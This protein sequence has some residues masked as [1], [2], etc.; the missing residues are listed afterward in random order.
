[1]ELG[2]LVPVLLLAVGDWIAVWRGSKTAEYFFKPAT[3]A[4]LIAIAVVLDAST[5]VLVALWLSLLGDVFLMLPRDLLVQGLLSFLF[6][7]VF[8][9]WAF[10]PLPSGWM[11]IAV[12]VGVVALPLFWRLKRGLLEKRQGRLV[13]PVAVY[14]ISLG[15]MVTAAGSSVFEDTEMGFVA[16]AGGVLFMVSDALIGW[17]RFVSPLAWA[18]V[19]IIVTYHLAQMALVTYLV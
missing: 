10:W 14:V 17:T 12:V 4:A 18:P 13:V 9:V 15:A 1:M 7:H 19:T 16:L 3:L 8:Y 11:W 5:P 2:Y 6:A